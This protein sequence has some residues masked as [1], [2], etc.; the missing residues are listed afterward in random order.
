MQQGPST[1]GTE[2]R[3]LREEDLTRK[4]ETH[5]ALRPLLAALRF[6]V[7]DVLRTRS[8]KAL[9]PGGGALEGPVVRGVGWREV[10]PEW[11]QWEG[12]AAGASLLK[13]ATVR[14]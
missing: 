12:E 13:V 10:R 2:E 6:R 7:C 11:G 4:R 1:H 9:P 3:Q 8:E 5:F 14:K